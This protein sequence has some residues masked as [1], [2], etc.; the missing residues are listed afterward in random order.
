MTL[1]LV[2]ATIIFSWIGYHTSISRYPYNKSTWSRFRLALD[3][4]ILVLYAH[5]VF[6]LQ[7]LHKVLLGLA[8]VFFFYVINGMARICEW[9]DWKVSKPWLSSLFA[10]AFIFE[11][12]LLE[13]WLA[14]YLQSLSW[15]LI[16]F[17][18]ALLVSYRIA[19]AKLG[20]PTLVVIGVDVDGV[21][22]EQ[23]PLPWNELKQREKDKI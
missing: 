20:Y 18:L 6:A 23:V 21:L 3:I 11:W 17:G 12:Y 2:Y 15:I 5:L 22:G 19:R 13:S 9:R 4:I 10:L 1:V 7:D 14:T 16:F 8:T